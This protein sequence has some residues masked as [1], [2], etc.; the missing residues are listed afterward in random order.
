[1]A[2]LLV[3]FIVQILKAKLLE[4]IQSYEDATFLGPKWCILMHLLAP[5]IVEIFKKY[6]QGINKS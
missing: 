6:L 2:Y 4:W 3:S 5:F 1:M